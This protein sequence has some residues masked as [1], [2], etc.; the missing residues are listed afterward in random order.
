MM[1]IA[2]ESGCENVIFPLQDVLGLDS[3]SRM[4][5]PGTAL[6]NWQ[7]RLVDFSGVAEALANVASYINDNRPQELE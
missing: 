1:V 6:G 3:T 2:S 5:V 7:W 4:N